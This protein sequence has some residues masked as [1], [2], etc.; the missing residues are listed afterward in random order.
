MQLRAGTF[1]GGIL[2]ETMVGRGTTDPAGA[3][4]TAAGEWYSRIVEQ[5]G[6]GAILIPSHN[7]FLRYSGGAGDLAWLEQ[8]AEACRSGGQ[9]QVQFTTT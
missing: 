1:Q 7:L 9:I 2:D 3:T 8:L 5:V 6:E 4:D